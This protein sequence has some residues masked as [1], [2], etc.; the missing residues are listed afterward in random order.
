MLTPDE[1]FE[2]VVSVCVRYSTDAV[3]EM[4]TPADPPTVA[5]IVSVAFAPGASEPTYHCPLPIA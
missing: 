4:D 2:P 5:V 1:S 3:L